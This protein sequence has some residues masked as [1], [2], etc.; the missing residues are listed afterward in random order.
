MSTKPKRAVQGHIQALKAIRCYHWRRKAKSQK[1]TCSGAD[2]STDSDYSW[3]QT[4]SYWKGCDIS[5]NIT[6]ETSES[7]AEVYQ[8]SRP[9]DTCKTPPAPME[10]V[11]SQVQ[12]K[13]IALRTSAQQK[14]RL[15]QMK[16][17]DAS[18]LSEKVF[19]AVLGMVSVSWC[20]ITA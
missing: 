2:P 12:Q 4:V 19:N 15:G 17:T 8:R 7:E 10:Q 9:K 3:S 16:N 18:L 13:A 14:G 11:A 20:C 6:A 5:H 1:I